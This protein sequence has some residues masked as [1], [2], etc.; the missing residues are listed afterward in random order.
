MGKGRARLGIP[1]AVVA[2]V[3]MLTPSLI[4]LMVSVP[5]FDTIYGNHIVQK[6]IKGILAAFVGLLGAMAFKFAVTINW[7]PLVL[8]IFLVAF[9]LL[10]FC[11]WSWE[12]P[13]RC[14]CCIDIDIVAAAIL[15]RCNHRDLH[16]RIPLCMRHIWR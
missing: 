16:Y 2:T 1:G 8:T 15:P 7:P 4:I 9:Y 10:R 13:W 14:R 5:H 3:G 6:A 11:W 12:Q